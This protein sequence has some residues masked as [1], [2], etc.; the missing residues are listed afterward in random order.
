LLDSGP[1]WVKKRR[2]GSSGTPLLNIGDSKLQAQQASEETGAVGE[3]VQ[4]VTGKSVVHVHGS[5]SF[6]FDRFLFLG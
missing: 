3:A 1:F 2:P 4:V 6:R 5:L